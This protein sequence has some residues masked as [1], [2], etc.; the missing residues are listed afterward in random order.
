MSTTDAEGVELARALIRDSGVGSELALIEK[1]WD[2][3]CRGAGLY[4]ETLFH[5]TSKDGLF[6][7][8]ASNFKITYSLERIHCLDHQE[9][10]A[11]PE[12]YG[13]LEDSKELVETTEDAPINEEFGAPMVSFCDLRLSELRVHMRDYG[14]YGIGMS[15]EWAIR[16]GLNPVYYVSSRAELVKRFIKSVKLLHSKIGQ[17]KQLEE[18]Y[19]DFLNL[20]RYM[21]NYEG[22]LHRKTGLVRENHRFANEREWRFVP[23][24]DNLAYSFASKKDMLDPTAKKVLDDRFA[25]QPLRFGPEDINYVIVKTDTE[26]AEIIEH[27]ANVKEK[28]PEHQRVRLMS[29][30]LTADQ[31]DYDV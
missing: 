3:E 6:G 9:G 2:E 18:A 14:R 21:K 22:P 16:R 12:A 17:D 13:E 11:D 1:A 20:H 10:H 31:I 28:Y 15:K 4:P 8:L 27:I 19:H 29:R 30:I 24:I 5:I 7:I 26:R 25:H 23:T